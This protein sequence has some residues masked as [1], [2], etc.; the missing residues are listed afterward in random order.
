MGNSLPS[1]KTLAQPPYNV[2]A[3][4][5]ASVKQL[6]QATAFVLHQYKNHSVQGFDCCMEL[7]GITNMVF[8]TDPLVGDH[9]RL[10]VSPAAN[11]KSSLL[12]D[13]SHLEFGIA[14]FVR[15]TKTGSAGGI[16]ACKKG[17][18][19]VEDVEALPARIVALL[20]NQDQAEAVLLGHAALSV[21]TQA[22]VDDIVSGWTNADAVVVLVD[23][24]EEGSGDVRRKVAGFF[25]DAFQRCSH[26]VLATGCNVWDADLLKAAD[27][28]VAMGLSG[29]DVAK[30]AA[31]VILLDDGLG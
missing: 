17:L 29:S 21:L 19:A 25:V 6:G 2:L 15:S 1:A 7:D 22:M 30:D 14:G 24:N 26:V 20:S 3:K 5:K 18:L 9:L 16:D 28:G 10:V 8:R 11:K 12:S 31:D 13:V 4:K 27:V 23:E